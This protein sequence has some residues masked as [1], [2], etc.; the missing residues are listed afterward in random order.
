VSQNCV[1]RISPPKV[2]VQQESM[3][4]GKALA[5]QERKG[6]SCGLLENLILEESNGQGGTHAV[7][8]YG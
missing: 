8:M 7:D 1:E 2:S 3:I 6:V 4:L 5:E